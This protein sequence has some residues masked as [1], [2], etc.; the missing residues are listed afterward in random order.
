MIQEPVARGD[1]QEAGTALRTSI[2]I[3][4]LA[5]LR[6]PDAVSTCDGCKSVSC[7][8]SS[9]STSFLNDNLTVEHCGPSA[10]SHVRQVASAQSSAPECRRVRHARTS[11]IMA[12]PDD[13]LHHIASHV[14]FDTR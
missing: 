4:T 12:L 7:M 5:V 9:R 11:S 14:D 10:A 3:S 6:M 2:R 8:S 13:L 1:S